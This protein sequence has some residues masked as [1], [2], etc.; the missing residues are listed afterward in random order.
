[1]SDN[2]KPANGSTE[3]RS[4]KHECNGPEH[5]HQQQYDMAI[6][7]APYGYDPEMDEAQYEEMYN[8]AMVAGPWAGMMGPSMMAN[9]FPPST[10][11]VEQ[12]QPTPPMA[13]AYGA[14]AVAAAAYHA[15]AAYGSDVAGYELDGE[16]AGGMYGSAQGEAGSY[17]PYEEGYGMG[18]MG[19]K[20]IPGSSR[21]M[22]PR[23][24]MGRQPMPGP[25]AAYA[26]PYMGYQQ[27]FMRMKPFGQRIPRGYGDGDG[28]DSSPEEKHKWYPPI[29]PSI[30]VG[31]EVIVRQT[32]TGTNSGAE[33]I[34]VQMT[35]LEDG[36]RWRKYGQ[37]SVK[38]NVHP[39]SYYKCTFPGCP[40]RKQVER[41]PDDPAVLLATYEGLHCHPP[42]QPKP[43]TRRL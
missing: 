25:T 22:L 34:T 26:M 33:R 3:F 13:S 31:K 7:P 5:Q 24:K 23:P 29:Q 19:Y 21:T 28:E 27:P 36:Y 18:E 38:G 8:A 20:N 11:W 42:V 1:M 9:G 17:P 40:C 43:G 6:T 16:M 14:A 37:K 30:L 39:R 12:Y 2:I 32:G 4:A 41:S 35:S 10:P 15:A